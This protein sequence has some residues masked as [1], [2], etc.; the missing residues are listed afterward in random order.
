MIIMQIKNPGKRIITMVVSKCA[1]TNQGNMN[2]KKTLHTF[3]QLDIFIRQSLHTY[4][5]VLICY[6]STTIYCQWR[7]EVKCVVISRASIVNVTVACT[8]MAENVSS[9]TIL[10]AGHNLLES[11]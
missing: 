3:I 1:R 7:Q 8:R 5:A 9:P 6:Y 2:D 11:R 10:V 4:N